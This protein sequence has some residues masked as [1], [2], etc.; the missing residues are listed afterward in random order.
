MCDVKQVMCLRDCCRPHA[1]AARD[2]Q[3]RGRG[4]AARRRCRAPR[5][6]G[7]TPRRPYTGRGRRLLASTSS[8]RAAA[9]R[10]GWLCGWAV[11]RAGRSGVS[12]PF[13]P[14]GPVA[15]CRI[16][17]SGKGSKAPPSH[18]PS[19]LPALLP[20]AFFTALPIFP[21]PRGAPRV[22]GTRRGHVSG[23]RALPPSCTLPETEPARPWPRGL[24]SSRQGLAPRPRSPCAYR[25]PH[26][27]MP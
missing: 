24:P 10:R 2:R 23:A 1:V 20:A 3:V 22:G 4:A 15:W 27:R 18:P 26:A 21:H 17:H 8:R 9:G 16:A 11:A 5:W 6:P 19:T 25:P 12:S 13:A 7:A 14:R